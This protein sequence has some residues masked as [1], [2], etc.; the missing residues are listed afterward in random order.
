MTSRGL[1]ADRLE[2][3]PRQVCLGVEPRQPDDDPAGVTAPVGR[4]EAG[5]GGHEVDAAVVLDA[6]RERLDLARVGDDPELVAQPLHGAA[7]DGDRALERVHRV[8]VAQLVCHGSDEP[9]LAADDLG[10]GVEQEEVAGAVGVLGLA[11]LE[12]DLA[13]GCRVLVAEHA[14]DRNVGQALLGRGPAVCRG[15]AGGTDAGEHRAGDTEQAEELVVPVEGR[16]VHQH[17]SARIRHVGGVHATVGPSGEVPH[18]P[19]VGGPEERVS[20]FGR[21]AQA[22]D[23]LEQPLQ[24]A[25]REVGGGGQAGLVPDDLAAAVAV[26]RRGDGGR[27]GVLPDKGV[28]EGASGAPV[29]DDGRLSLVGHSDGGEVTH[30]DAR[31]RGRGADDGPGS[32]P[33]LQRVV[34]DPAGPGEDLLVLELVA[35][36]HAPVV[37]EDHEPGARRPLV[38]RSN[39]VRHDRETSGGRRRAPAPSCRACRGSGA[40]HGGERPP[41]ADAGLEARLDVELGTEHDGEDLW[42]DGE[43]HPDVGGLAPVR[44]E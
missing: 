19:R 34:L 13:D 43:E 12:A 5:E 10:A 26:Q 16:Q 42:R 28:V 3:G 25:A 24:L 30:R 20:A 21:G 27:P 14:G 1:V 22:V 40:V 15:V 11:G 31:A 41:V 23:V 37:V 18:D 17:R 2:G 38:D 29:P 35:G 32:V 7:R 39:E 33:D 44:L 8:G 6:R 9:V 4:E 36:D